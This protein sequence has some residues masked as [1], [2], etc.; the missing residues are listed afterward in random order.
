MRF[1][2]QEDYKPW[3]VH[4]SDV[5]LTGDDTA[6]SLFNVS[7]SLLSG[8]PK[9]I[10]FY[11]NTNSSQCGLTGSPIFTWSSGRQPNVVLPYRTFL[12]LIMTSKSNQ[13]GSSYSESWNTVNVSPGAYYVCA[14][15][16]DGYNTSRWVS[17]T[18]VVINH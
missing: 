11:A 10:N 4:L 3:A 9:T 18:P 8:T 13:V 17:Q 14:V 16:N 7:W 1:D 5:K 12:P 15:A 2:F 6:N